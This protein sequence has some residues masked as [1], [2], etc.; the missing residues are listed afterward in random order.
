M[1]TTSKNPNSAYWI[2]T[3]LALFWNIIGVAQFF[4]QAMNTETF[5]SQFTEEQLLAIDNLPLYY[6]LIFAIAVFASF[7]GVVF[8]IARRTQAVAFFT[9]GLIAVC[10]QVGYNLFINELKSSYGPADYAMLII[11]PLVAAFLW[12]YANSANRRGWLR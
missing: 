5:R 7:L 11:L 8:L 4:M 3:I 6:I 2:I 9:V 12:Y 1:N 10:M